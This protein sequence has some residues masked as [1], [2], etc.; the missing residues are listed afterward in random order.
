MTTTPNYSFTLNGTLYSGNIPGSSGAIDTGTPDI[1]GSVAKSGLVSFAAA[2]G[3][4]VSGELNLTSNVSLTGFGNTSVNDLLTSGTERVAADNVSYLTLTGAATDTVAVTAN[5]TGYAYFTG[6]EKGIYAIGSGSH[7]V[8]FSNVG[9][10]SVHGI[11]DA[12]QSLTAK[13]YED[14]QAAKTAIYN[15]GSATVNLAATSIQ[16]PDNV[17][18]WDVGTLTLNGHGAGLDLNAIN[19][20]GVVAIYDETQLS[21]VENQ[22]SAGLMLNDTDGHLQGGEF[23][24]MGGNETVN[25]SQSLDSSV[26]SGANAFTFDLTHTTAAGTGDNITFDQGFAFTNGVAG[27]DAVFALGAGTANITVNTIA[28]GQGELARIQ[29]I[30]GTGAATIHGGTGGSDVTFKAGTMDV[31]GGSGQ[32]DYTFGSYG[33][34]TTLDTIEDFKVGTDVLNLSASVENHITFTDTQGGTDITFGHHTIDLVG[35]HGFNASDV[36]WTPTH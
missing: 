7:T 6:L 36:T 22:A 29:F 32:N 1:T 23:V 21:Y 20:L 31:T 2:A 12:G 10:A 30:G 26:Q 34:G 35:V 19:G 33:V 9:T 25:V 27:H 16:T 4:Y 18:A 8:E 13:V 15:L 5:G 24:L 14:T 28:Q 3:D 17:K 11:G